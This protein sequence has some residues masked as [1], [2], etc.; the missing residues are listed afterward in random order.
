MASFDGSEGVADVAVKAN[1]VGSDNKKGMDGAELK[2]NRAVIESSPNSKAAA[3]MMVELRQTHVK[4]VD[5]LKFAGYVSGTGGNTTAEMVDEECGSTAVDVATRGEVLPEYGAMPYKSAGTGGG[6]VKKGG[7]Y[8]RGGQDGTDLKTSSLSELKITEEDPGELRSKGA[9]RWQNPHDMMDSRTYG[10]DKGGGEEREEGKA[11]LRVGDKDEQNRNKNKDW[12]EQGTEETDDKQQETREPGE[13]A[14]GQG[15]VGKGRGEL[16]RLAKKE[17]R[18]RC[19]ERADIWKMLL[20]GD[21]ECKVFAYEV[22]REAKGGVRAIELFRPEAW[23][24]TMLMRDGGLLNRSIRRDILINY[25]HHSHT[26]QS[27]TQ[28]GGP[29]DWNNRSSGVRLGLSVGH[30]VRVCEFLP[31]CEC[32]VDPPPFE[33]RPLGRLEHSS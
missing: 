25:T 3:E 24:N 31:S 10:R 14:D 27:Y 17:L 22:G 12:K 5:T 1:T 28:R 7:G 32:V 15:G 4:E 2:R 11:G 9:Y 30:A 21:I 18:G 33:H 16:W 23:H 6:S 8:E 19:F 13:G 26:H 20:D 29:P